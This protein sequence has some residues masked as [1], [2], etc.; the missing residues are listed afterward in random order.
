MSTTTYT[1]TIGGF[2]KE[3]ANTTTA[4]ELAKQLI[5]AGCFAL[6]TGWQKKN[7]KTFPYVA[8]KSQVINCTNLA[9]VNRSLAIIETITR[10]LNAPINIQLQTKP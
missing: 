6:Q 2:T 4:G 3:C 1:L 10:Q 7:N 9:S 5:S 8:I